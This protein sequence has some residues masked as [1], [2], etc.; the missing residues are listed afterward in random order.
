MSLRVTPSGVRS[1]FLRDR[2]H[3]TPFAEVSPLYTGR[4]PMDVWQWCKCYSPKAQRE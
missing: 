4:Q 2:A 3:W 1:T